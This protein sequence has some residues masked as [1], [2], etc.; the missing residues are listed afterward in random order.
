MKNKALVPIFCLS[1]LLFQAGCATSPIVNDIHSGNIESLKTSVT[2]YNIESEHKGLTPLM[3]AA[4]EG[5]L[6]AVNILLEQH[7]NINSINETG[8]TALIYAAEEGK[9][10]NVALLLKRNANVSI[11]DKEGNT[12][13]I[14]AAANNHIEV[15][16]VLIKNGAA[17]NATNNNKSTAL[18]Y[19]AKANHFE[20]VKFLIES[21]ADLKI[22][23]YEGDY[24][25]IKAA[26]S[27]NLEIVKYLLE[28]GADVNCVNTDGHT[29]L[30]M[31]VTFGL[32]EVANHLISIPNINFNHKD[33]YGNTALHISAITM[34]TRYDNMK[35][36]Q[37]LIEKSSTINDKNKLGCTPLL[38]AA[39]CG[40]P[41]A[42]DL[43]LKN[44]ADPATTNNANKTAYDYANYYSNNIKS[45]P[46]IERADMIYLPYYNQ[47]WFANDLK[48]DDKRNYRHIRKTLLTYK[49]GGIN[50]IT[51]N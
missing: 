9:A 2:K 21:G 31:A 47:F 49:D 12:A 19:A 23:D 44:G 14:L 51:K 27:G 45:V 7:A 43:L 39:L 38:L 28:K 42:V 13:L 11:K 24:P 22:A 20:V 1:A 33:K 40:S 3:W 37:N 10:D 5:K 18:L 17:I 26:Y 34:S 15:V 41:I 16:R 48:R 8:R 46:D 30:T 25:I 35:V 36:F 50:K 4:K 6:E 29:P 32:S